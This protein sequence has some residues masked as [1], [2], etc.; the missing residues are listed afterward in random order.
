MLYMSALTMRKGNIYTHYVEMLC[1]SLASGGP[2]EAQ[3]V[4]AKRHI[5]VLG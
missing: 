3:V 4:R 2:A 5:H 1:Y